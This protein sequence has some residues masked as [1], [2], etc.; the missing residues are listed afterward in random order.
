MAVGAIAISRELRSPCI[1][2]WARSASHRPR[3]RVRSPGIELQFTSR[4]SCVLERRMLALHDR[5]LHRRRERVEVHFLR[6]ACRK[7]PSFGRVKG[8]THLKE[9]VLEAH[10]PEAHRTPAK[11]RRSCRSDGIIAKIDDTIELA[12]GAPHGSRK[13]FKIKHDRPVSTSCR[14]ASE[15]DRAKIADRCFIL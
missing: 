8:K 4:S 7:R 1:R 3:L 14:V 11:I 2:I 6:D 9:H 5:K 10:D 13:F 12:Y 15:I